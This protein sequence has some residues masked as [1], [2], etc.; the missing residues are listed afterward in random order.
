MS[1]NITTSFV[2]QY[3]SNVNLLS[4]QMGSKLRG[5]VDEES[6]VGKNAFFEQIGS[7]AAVL[8]TSRHGDTPQ[9]DTPHSRRRVSLSDY[10]WA[11][12][13]DDQDKVRAL[14]D[15][16]SAYAKNAAAAM[17]RAMDDVII[18]AFNASASTGVAGGTSTALPSTQK[19]ATSN[20]SDGLTIA[21]LLS[22]KKILDNND[23]DPSRKR[24]IVC[25]PQQV[26]DLLAVTQVTSSDFNTVKALAQGDINS[27][28][29]F[30]FIMSTRLSFDA[31]NTDDRLIFAYTEDA[32]KLAI[33]SDIKAQI[34]ERA[35]KS[36]STQVYYAMSLGAVRM[37]EKAV[38]Q[39]PCN[40]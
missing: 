24:F 39:I 31:T 1:I 17:N 26:A 37:E 12:L 29:G 35:D 21:K 10:E 8:R 23:I 36:Y 19:F 14:V 11:D 4:Q 30:E 33:G 2:E 32:I 18:T 38:V 9:I 3:S 34:S 28:L 25:G 40:E 27:F 6:I 13:I 7:T 22:A 20:Q 5:S 16:T 15:P